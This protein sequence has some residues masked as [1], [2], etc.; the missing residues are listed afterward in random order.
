MNKRVQKFLEKTA[1]YSSMAGPFDPPVTMVGAVVSRWGPGDR[2]FRTKRDTLSL[3]LITMGNAC[4]E[5]EGR[6]GLVEK[7][8]IFLAHKG[9]S[10]TLRT[11]DE[12]FMHKRSLIMEGPA[13]DMLVGSLHLGGVD[14][15]APRNAPA[16]AGLFRE[17]YRLLRER[18]EGMAVDVSAQ[19]YRILL[20]LSES[21]VPDYPV[22]LRQAMK[23]VDANIHR[24]MTVADIAHAAGVSVRHGSRLFHQYLACSPM[25]FSIRSRMALAQNMLV[26]TNQP[27][28]HIAAALGY[29]NQLY[30]SAIFRRRVGVSPTDYRRK[31]MSG[32]G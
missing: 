13:L 9:C 29:D 30:F 2:F 14:V 5:Q 25:E 6:Q 26:N 18:P 3:S 7:G 15:V 16:L 32:P 27:V 17:A 31:R 23:Y 4:F 11:G 21:R 24:V 28:K 1:S 12:G 22:S 8:Q 10:Q 20:A 19:A